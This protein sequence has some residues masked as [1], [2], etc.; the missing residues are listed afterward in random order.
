MGAACAKLLYDKDINAF[1]ILSC[2]S[3]DSNIKSSYAR[4]NLPTHQCSLSNTNRVPGIHSPGLQWVLSI[5]AAPLFPYPLW[6]DLSVPYFWSLAFKVHLR[7]RPAG[8]NEFQL[9]SLGLGLG[10]GP[11]RKEQFGIT[12]QSYGID[13][14]KKWPESI[15]GC[16]KQDDQCPPHPTPTQHPQC[17][18]EH[19][20][21]AHTTTFTLS[22][23]T[24]WDELHVTI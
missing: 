15:K 23:T 22:S 5:P 2:G 7:N 14:K 17:R 6:F 20:A 12:V 1:L 19:G 24:P 10:L 8:S 11:G 18:A 21:G 16:S 9:I 13:G 3:E 4:Q